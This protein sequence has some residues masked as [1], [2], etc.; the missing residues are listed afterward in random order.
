MCTRHNIATSFNSS[1][2]QPNT[3]STDYPSVPELVKAI[4][5]EIAC[6][7]YLYQANLID[8]FNCFVR[9][10]CFMCHVRKFIME[11]ATKPRQS[12]RSKTSECKKK[13]CVVL[14]Y[15]IN[16]MGFVCCFWQQISRIQ[17]H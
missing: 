12:N 5:A 8:N 3:K 6:V 7:F 2:Q 9:H 13:N 1:P 14:Y 4:I 10:W 11:S 17:I 15:A 16:T